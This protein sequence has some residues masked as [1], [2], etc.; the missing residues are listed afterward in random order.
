MDTLTSREKWALFIGVPFAI[1]PGMI[2]T[3][4]V[5]NLFHLPF[6]C[7]LLVAAV[8]SA[9]AGVISTPLAFRGLI[10]GAVSGVGVMLGI[11]AY[12]FARFIFTDD[13]VFNNYEIGLG[14]ILGAVPGSLLYFKWARA[15]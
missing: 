13:T 10:T 4:F 7:W 1:L 12:V 9:V 5:P 15:S 6:A 3:G 14:G 11:L 2:V 8:G